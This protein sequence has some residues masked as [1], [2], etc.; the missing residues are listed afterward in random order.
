PRVGVEDVDDALVRAHLELLARV[1]VDERA[2]NHGVLAD[3]GG[4]RDRAGS[5]RVRPAG[6]VHDLVR[7]LVQDS[8]VV[9]LEP[10]PDLL[11][12]CLAFSLFLVGSWGYLMTSVATPEPTVLPPSRIANRSPCS[13]AIGSPSVMSITT[14]SPGIVISTP[15]GSFT[16]PVTSVV[17]M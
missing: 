4:K 14:L 15:S 8:M 12:H 2:A 9:G 1:L 7:R 3:L 16:S 10:D 11:R 13:M 17:R 6:G 5:A